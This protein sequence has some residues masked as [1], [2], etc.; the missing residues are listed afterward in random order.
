M[1]DS[2]YKKRMDGESFGRADLGFPGLQQQLLDAVLDT[3]VPTVLI[4]TGGQ[5]FVLDNSTMRSNAIMHSFLGGEFTSATLVEIITGEVN[6]SGKLTVSMPQLNGAIPAFYHYLPSDNMG[7]D[8]RRLGFESAYQ[9]PVLKK[10]SPM[11]FGFGLSYTTFNISAPKAGYKKGNFNVRVNVKTTGNV[12]GKEVVQVYHRPNTSVG[13]EFPVRRLVRF[14]KV[15]L[16][17]G[18]SKEVEF[19]IPN[20]EMGYYVNAKLKVQEGMYS[21]WAGSSSSIEDLKAVNVTVSL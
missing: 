9:W 6:P 8:P 13:I 21:F 16:A 18:E 7:G 2:L 12:A 11:P 20:K 4:L 1:R 15:D 17:A 3:G 10:D 19:S 14:E 5:P